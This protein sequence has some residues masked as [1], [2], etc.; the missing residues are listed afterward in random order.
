MRLISLLVLTSLKVSQ[1]S[2][3]DL[4]SKINPAI[5]K[6][7]AR[8][9]SGCIYKYSNILNID[10]KL[11]AAVIAVESNFNSKA[12]G[13]SHGEIGLMQL[14]PEFHLV[15][16]K[17]QKKRKQALFNMDINIETG[18]RYIAKLKREFSAHSHGIDFIEHYNIGPNR[19]PS[20]YN[21]TK[22]IGKYYDLFR[23]GNDRPPLP[24][25]F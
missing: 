12:L 3:A 20:S 9:I 18:V 7:Q 21:Y 14:R 24:K 13:T 5:D 16:V 23:G 17:D 19:V 15:S 25:T 6:T 2:V 22:K 11:V 4:I 8:A 1:P 10:P